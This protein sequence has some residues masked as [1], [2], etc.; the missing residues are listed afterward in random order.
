M[1]GNSPNNV[2]VY[3]NSQ[4]HKQIELKVISNRGAGKVVFSESFSIA[5][6]NDV[7]KPNPAD[8]R[9]LDKIS[10]IPP[11]QHRIAVKAVGSGSPTV[12]TEELWL[13]TP[14]YP[15]NERLDIYINPYDVLRVDRAIFE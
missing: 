12:E 15:A 3:N 1:K 2:G 8:A 9:A 10:D 11:G 14:G 4:E 7:P 5:G 6:F 13:A